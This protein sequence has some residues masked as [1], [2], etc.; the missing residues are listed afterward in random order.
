MNE[1]LEG[2]GFGVAPA[3]VS[4][5]RRRAASSDPTRRS[6]SDAAAGAPCSTGWDSRCKARGS[7]TKK[8][9][10]PSCGS[11]RGT[12]NTGAGVAATLALAL[13]IVGCAAGSFGAGAGAGSGVVGVGGDGGGGDALT[14]AVATAPRASP[15]SACKCA[16]ASKTSLHC[17]QRTQPSDTRSWSGTTLNIVV[18]AGHRVIRL[19]YEPL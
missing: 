6:R 14:T 13:T 5:V 17:P 8:G 19:I 4:A 16:F 9:S 18:Q 11:A 1:A 3:A 7:T 10:G 15:D 12:D 2:R